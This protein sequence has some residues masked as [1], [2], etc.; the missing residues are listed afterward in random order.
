[1]GITRKQLS[2][3]IDDVILIY[4]DKHLLDYVKTS[5][6]KH[7]HNVLLTAFLVMFFDKDEE[8]LNKNFLNL[9]DFYNELGVPH[10]YVKYA[11]ARLFVKHKKWINNSNIVKE[12]YHKKKYDICK[13]IFD[14]YSFRNT[15]SDEGG[16]KDDDFF[17]LEDTGIDGSIDDMHYEDAK[18]I[19][20]KKYFDMYPLDYS[21]LDE[22]SINKDI[23]VEILD[24][25]LEYSEEFLEK[26]ISTL[27][28]LD[29][30]L[31]LTFANKDFEDI[32]KGIEKLI[33]SLGNLDRT[34][35]AWDEK[36]LYNILIAFIEDLLKWLD[37]IFVKQDALDIHYFDASLYASIAQFEMLFQ[38]G[39]EESCDD[40]YFKGE[41]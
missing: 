31:K 11:L 39:T 34:N 22:I 18:K 40:I 10:K 6:E 3:L 17:F 33:V 7:K 36:I 25:Y 30:S 16:C 19:S 32:G 1:M 5:D 29:A 35:I 26:L 38:T 9:L 37:K 2:S 41:L 21:D 14:G 8:N 4:Q 13:N 23:L 27:I 12:S 28:K 24:D 15:A 20:A